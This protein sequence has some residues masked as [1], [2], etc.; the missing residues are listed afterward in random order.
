MQNNAIAYFDTLVAGQVVIKQDLE[1]SV[2]NVDG[3]QECSINQPTGDI[4]ISNYQ[5]AI[6]GTFT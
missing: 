5:K 3:V 4:A 2:C 1:N 6:L